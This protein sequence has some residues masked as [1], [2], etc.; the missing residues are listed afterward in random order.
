MKKTD[1]EK[2]RDLITGQVRQDM[3]SQGFFD[4]RFVSRSIP[5]KKVYSRKNK[6]K[7]DS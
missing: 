7:Y 4:G 3:K 1:G 2:I 5:S 6:H